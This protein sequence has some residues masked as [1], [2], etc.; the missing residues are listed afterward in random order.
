[1]GADAVIISLGD[2]EV[3]ATCTTSAS[4]PIQVRL[5]DGEP[6]D[7][8]L[9]ATDTYKVTQ[10]GHSWLVRAVADGDRVWSFVNGEV[11]VVD[12]QKKTRKRRPRDGGHLQGLTAP[13]PATVTKLLAAEGQK[14]EKGQTLILLEAMKMELPIKAPTDGVIRKINCK[15]R[16]IVQAETQLIEFE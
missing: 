12:V 1:M 16:E 3:E 4:G 2:W 14:V 8:R 10:N 15:E 7:V 6:F 9:V 5:S 11:V 13:M